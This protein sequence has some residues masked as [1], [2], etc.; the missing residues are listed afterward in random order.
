LGTA[1]AHLQDLEMLKLIRRVVAAG[2]G[3]SQV[4]TWRCFLLQQQLDLG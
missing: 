1:Q 2:C 4:M 3:F